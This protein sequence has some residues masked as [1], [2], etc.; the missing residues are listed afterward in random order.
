MSNIFKSNSRF[1]ALVE[2]SPLPKKEKERENETN[3]NNN[4]FVKRDNEEPKFSSFRP[5]DENEKERRRLKRELEFQK[6]KEIVEA[7][8]ERIKSLSL[9]INPTN[10][11]ELY[12]D[13]K[14]DN[15]I[16]K[17]ETYLEKLKHKEVTSNNDV[18]PDLV[19]LKPGWFILKRDN[20]TGKTIIKK[21]QAK[22][23]V[24]KI[25]EAE[26]EAEVTVVEADEELV[27]TAVGEDVNIDITDELIKLHDKRTQEYIDNYG[28]EEWERIFKV[29]NWREEEAY[30]E[31][32]EQV[33]GA[34]DN[35]VDSDYD[36]EDEDGYS[37]NYDYDC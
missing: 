13:S 33:L 3:N 31:M 1:D 20:L 11:P 28:Y 5:L 17:C 10:F 34:Y 27:G 8:K 18:D 6:Q 16:S 35:L 23:V 32:M 14:Q 15:I 7:E 4:S 22:N 36:G 21:K 12:L 26:A 25:G 2:N 29:P 30:L 24:A 9:Q 19:N 37:N